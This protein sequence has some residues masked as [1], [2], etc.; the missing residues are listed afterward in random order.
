[1]GRGRTPAHENGMHH[2][3]APIGIGNA[4]GIGIDIG[5]NFDA[6]ADS[7]PNPD[8]TFTTMTRLLRVVALEASGFDRYTPSD[9]LEAEQRESMSSE[10][11]GITLERGNGEQE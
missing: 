2:M 8:L 3:F 6:D 5:G 11:A 9:H 1:M 7:D 4:I 10:D